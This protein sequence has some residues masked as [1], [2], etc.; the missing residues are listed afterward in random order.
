MKELELL[1]AVDP[2]PASLMA[3]SSSAVSSMP[4]WGVAEAMAAV[5]ESFICSS[6]VGLGS[7]GGSWGAA[8]SMV[9]TIATQF[10]IPFFCGGDLVCSLGMN[11]SG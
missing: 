1:L 9:A 10:M 8:V 11:L 4:G 5:V 6:E 2:P 3:P 7:T